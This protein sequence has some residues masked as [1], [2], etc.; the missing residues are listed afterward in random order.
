MALA[1][2][3]IGTTGAKIT[4]YSNT[5]ELLFNS[6]CDYKVNRTASEHEIDVNEIWKST[7]QLIKDATSNVNDIE[8]I[9]VTSFGETFVLLDEN[10]KPI[11]NALL[12][13]D[14]RGEEECLDLRK[15]IG[16]EKLQ[17]IT[18][19]N[20]HGMYSISKL[21]W[22]KKNAPHDFEKAKRILLIC[23]FIVYKLTGIPIIDYSLASRTMA[24]DINTLTWSNEILDCC[25]I[26][27]NLFS[28]PVRSGEGE[29]ATNEISKEL[30]LKEALIIPVGHDQVAAGI[31][32]GAFDDEIGVDGA[33][34][35]ECITPV[36]DK[37]IKKKV[38][39]E[40]N[41]AIVPYVI[42]DK[43][44]TYAFSFTGGALVSWFV[45]NFAK[46][47]KENSNN[48]YDE[49]EKN[50]T[51]E[52]T[53][54]LVL[55][56]FAGAATPYMDTNAKGAVVGLTIE[57]S[58]SDF[59]K[60]ILEGV[61]YEMKINMDNINKANI[62]P[63]ELYA[64]GGCA[65]SKVWMQIKTDVLNMP[66]TELANS[67]AGAVGSAMIG[68]ISI[69]VFKDLEE[70]SRVLIKKKDTYYPNLEQHKKYMVHFEKYKKLYKAVK[71]VLEVTNE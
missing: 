68:G 13:T 63:K 17:D 2:L 54:I 56:H 35:V 32:S 9:G 11:R 50:M 61:V 69:G 14:P 67:D 49:L 5:G 48:V 55:P 57:H 51:H 21:M 52:P 20:P 22:I 42:K 53:G 59:Y 29:K 45:D 27:K 30:G 40:G 65:K 16:K 6:Y 43:Y 62:K 24:F 28:I 64:T 36:F 15:K 31:G 19:L 46:F 33:G 41:Y 38:M 37:S 58:I 44:V 66:I 7:K 18:G 26:D 71:S 39:Y 23:D 70:A 47:E 12:Y 10:D 60:A 4:V 8:V 3:D 1:G 25:G 34:T